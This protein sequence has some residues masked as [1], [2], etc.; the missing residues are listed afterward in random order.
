MTPRFWEMLYEKLDPS[1]R[2]EK[3]VQ[4]RITYLNNCLYKDLLKGAPI[5]SEKAREEYKR[6]R[7]GQR[8]RNL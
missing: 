5:L 6:R 8:D 3:Q 1:H 4:N 7:L 2:T